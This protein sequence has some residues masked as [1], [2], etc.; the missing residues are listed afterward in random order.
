MTD[1][2]LPYS[3]SLLLRAMALEFV[4]G[5]DFR[6]LF[7]SLDK[8]RLCR[9]VTDFQRA[10][11]IL[12]SS[13]DEGK[14]ACE[15]TIS[16]GAAPLR[17]LTAVAATL[18]DLTVTIDVRGRLAHRPID[19]LLDALGT[20]GADIRKEQRED[21]FQMEIRGG[22]LA[23]TDFEIEASQSSQFLSALLLISSR[24]KGWENFKLPDSSVSQPYL[25]MTV[26]MLKH[27]KENLSQYVEADWSAAAFFFCNALLLP[28]NQ[29]FFPDLKASSLQGDSFIALICRSM[30]LEVIPSE[31]GILLKKEGAKP[32][33]EGRSEKNIILP[34]SETPDIVPALTVALALKGIRFIFFGVGH[35]RHKE[36]DRIEVL[37][38]EMRKIGFRLEYQC[39][40]LSWNGE[41]IQPD[42]HPVIDPHRDH[43]MAMAFLPAEKMGL[44]EID[45][46]NVVDKSFPNFMEEIEKL[47]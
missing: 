29:C 12:Q 24:I 5:H 27:G 9:D 3:K 2:I 41:T 32:E 33:Y 36:S 31:K 6:G 30:G 34:M 13:I 4:E 20:L 46:M 40:V 45:D 47:W 25:Y 28:F 17:F 8:S 23:Y 35:L 26:E 1:I 38:S 15:V 18:M 7:S 44:A 19:P 10:L 43:R 21:G 22:D 42:P 11:E 39:G 16:E 37:I 14:S